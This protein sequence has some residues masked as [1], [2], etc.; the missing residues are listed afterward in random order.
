MSAP[1][2]TVAICTWNRA[3]L[4][5]ITLEQ[6]VS[7]QVPADASWELIVVNN[8]CTDATDS[9]IEAYQDR[10]P[11]RSVAERRPG[12]SHARNRAVSEAEGEYIIWT[13]DDVLVDPQW[14]A[15]YLRAFA[16][17]PEAAFF[18]GPIEPWFEG[19][20]PKWL[21]AVLPRVA[22][23]YALRDFGT[24]PIP[25]DWATHTVPYGANFAVRNDVQKQFAFDP[26]FGLKQ[27]SVMRGEEVRMIEMV[28][29][30][31][32][33]GWWV[34][35][36][37]VKHFLPRS[38]QTTA[39]LRAYCRGMGELRT[40]GKTYDG[41]RLFGAPRYLWLEAAKAEL[42]YYALR[43]GKEPEDWIESLIESGALWGELKGWRT[44]HASTRRD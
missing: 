29:A 15:A 26:R 23:C 13:D 4:L 18:G 3:R 40:V 43:M 31:G 8:A 7:L 37:R 12:Q 22:S 39:Y 10:L 21:S 34:P 9:V 14:L 24:Q 20:P 16:E 35:D 41:P 36:A 17:R 5:A 27:E 42:R 28:L 33:G 32:Y 25:F 38:R 1:D 19:D 30:A 2:A 44:A 11:I 6:M